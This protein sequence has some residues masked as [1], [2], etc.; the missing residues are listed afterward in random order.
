MKITLTKQQH[1]TESVSPPDGPIGTGKLFLAQST[2]GQRQQMREVSGNLTA[3][4]CE[5]PG[6]SA[7]F[8]KFSFTEEMRV[9]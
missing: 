3:A 1:N 9:V 2:C 8:V 7:S 4:N 5:E 6:L